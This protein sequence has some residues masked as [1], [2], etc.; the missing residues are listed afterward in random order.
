M[1]TRSIWSCGAL[2]A[3]ALVLGACGSSP[4]GS[5][6]VKPGTPAA[7][8]AAAQQAQQKGDY[9]AVEKNLD[10]VAGTENEFTLRARIWLLAVES[11]VA[12]ANMEWADAL[13]AGRKVARANQSA[14]LKLSSDARTVASQN[15][16]SFADNGHSLLAAKDAEFAVVFPAPPGDK[17]KPAG[18]E[19]I[20]KGVLPPD[21]EQAALFTKLTQRG[22]L[23]S[24]TRLLSPDGDLDTTK[25]VDAKVKRA[26]LLSYYAG[27][28]VELAELYGAKKLNYAGRAKML[29]AEAQ[30]ALAGVE[31]S[32]AK[33]KLS[34]RIEEALKKLP[35]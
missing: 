7:F 11:G 16:L 6:S 29:Y 14:F 20:T 9:V 24:V 21:A 3:L 13:D 33:T 35:K 15:A 32:P 23:Q 34:K 5:K 8:W 17:E 10:R 25:P 31:A 12:R 2:T 27:E 30:S 1:T 18:L 28:A 19:K 22:V 4:S 26:A